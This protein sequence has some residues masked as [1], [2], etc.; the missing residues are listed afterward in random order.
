MIP[1]HAPP[2]QPSTKMRVLV[3]DDD[4]DNR[5]SL[6]M[7]LR[8]WGHEVSCT[9]DG[10]SALEAAR[11]FRPQAVLLDIGLPGMDGWET[12]KKLREQPGACITL[13]VALSGYGTEKDV[14]RSAAVGF[15]VHLTKP[16]DPEQIRR[17]LSGT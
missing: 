1:R 10:P 15:T 5:D 9:H 12:G 17:L 6:V 16:A 14:A 3:V 2:L 11:S 8:L 7:L 4:Q 13:L